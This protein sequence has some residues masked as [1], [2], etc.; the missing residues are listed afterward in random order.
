MIKKSKVAKRDFIVSGTCV[1]AAFGQ[2]AGAQK[3]GG[4][5]K[6]GRS[7]FSEFNRKQTETESETLCGGAT[8]ENR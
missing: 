1:G 8:W 6:S 7:G 2:N 3:G 5:D 4:E